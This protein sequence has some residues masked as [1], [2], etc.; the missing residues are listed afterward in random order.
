MHQAHSEWLCAVNTMKHNVV[1]SQNHSDTSLS[2]NSLFY[3]SGPARITLTQVKIENFLCMATERVGINTQVLGRDWPIQ[4]ATRFV[5]VSH[6]DLQK[7][8]PRPLRAQASSREQGRSGKW[9][10]GSGMWPGTANSGD[11]RNPRAFA[12]TRTST[13]ELVRS[14]KKTPNHSRSGFCD[15]RRTVV[16]RK[17][18]VRIGLTCS[19]SAAC[20]PAKPRGWAR[21][22]ARTPSSRSDCPRHPCTSKR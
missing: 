7:A 8:C 20:G 9:P 13:R 18:T 10:G 22:R 17:T 11:W 1:I 5:H 16:V 15:W 4:P 2:E 6:V 21:S 19:P 12:G 3:T 14:G